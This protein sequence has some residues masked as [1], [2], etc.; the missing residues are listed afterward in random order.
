MKIPATLQRIMS[1][2]FGNIDD[3]DVYIDDLLIATDFEEIHLQVLNDLFKRFSKYNL[4]LAMNKCEFLQNEIVFLGQTISSKVVFG[5]PNHIN[6][7]LNVSKSKKRKQLERLLGLVQ[8]VAKFIPNYEGKIRN[9]FGKLKEDGTNA[10]LLRHPRQN[11]QF[12]VQCDTSNNFTIFIVI[13]ASQYYAIQIA[14]IEKAFT[15]SRELYDYDELFEK[16]IF[17]KAQ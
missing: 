5:N 17:R 1:S 15:M 3:V 9:A 6:K 10:K 16:N 4:R 2:L 14:Q 12:I 13:E 8:Y 11:E 7:V